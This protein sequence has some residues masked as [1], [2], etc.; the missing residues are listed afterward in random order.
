MIIQYRGRVVHE[1]IVYRRQSKGHF[2]FETFKSK[3]RGGKTALKPNL[4]HMGDS[5]VDYLIVSRGYSF[6]TLFQVALERHN[7]EYTCAL[8]EEPLHWNYHVKALQLKWLV[9][10]LSFCS[11]ALSQQS[12][13]ELCA[14]VICKSVFFGATGVFD[15]NRTPSKYEI[16]YLWANNRRLGVERSKYEMHTSR[17]WPSDLDQKI[18]RLFKYQSN[19]FRTLVFYRLY[20]ILNTCEAD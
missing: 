18:S 15:S 3:Q 12:F 4:S 5:K 7:F 19:S 16:K 13:C 14:S 8:L 20:L 9:R 10:C 6:N 11:T 17:L 1:W 2:K